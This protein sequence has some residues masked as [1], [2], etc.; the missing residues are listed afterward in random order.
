MITPYATNNSRENTVAT[1]PPV[2]LSP[3]SFVMSTDGQSSDYGAED[4]GEHGT[5]FFVILFCF[6]WSWS[7][8]LAKN[9]MY[10]VRFTTDTPCFKAR[11]SQGAEMRA[12]RG[13]SEKWTNFVNSLRRPIMMVLHIITDHAAANPKIYVTTTILLSLLLVGAGLFTNFRVESDE[14]I[15]YTPFGSRPLQHQAWIDDESGFP[16]TP[17][18][19][20]LLVHQNG[21]NVLHKEGARRAMIALNTCF[22]TP[23]YDEFC[24]QSE[25]GTCELVSFA[26]FWNNSLATFDAQIQTDRDAISIMSSTTFPDGSPV[27]WQN[28]YGRAVRDD[29]GMLVEAFAY[30]MH[31]L[32]PDVDDAEAFEQRALDTLQALRDEWMNEEGNE[33]QLDLFVERSFSDEFS[34]A[35]VADIPLVPMVFFI[36]SAFT[37]FVFL[38]RDWVY[39][40]SLLGFGA[41]VSVLLS[42]MT[43]YGFLFIIGVPFTSMTQILPFV[44]FGIG[45]DDAFIISNAYARQDKR[46]SPQERIH[47]TMDEVGLSVLL[48]TMTSVVAFGLG[49]MSTI[50]TVYWLCLYAFPTIFIDFLYQITFFVALIIIDERRVQDKRRDC[51]VCFAV[52]SRVGRDETQEEVRESF[53]DRLMAAFAIRVL[54]RWWVKIIVILAFT[55]LLVGCG[56]SA[57]RLT[58]EFKFTDVL[59]D[60]SYVATFWEAYRD[61]AAQSGV[62]MQV[63]FRDVD[64]SDAAIQDQME[65]YVNDLINDVPQVQDQEVF[66]WLRDFKSFVNRTSSVR[67]LPFNLQVTRFLEED[68]YESLYG[69]HIVR[70]EQGNILSSRTIVQMQDIDQDDVTQTIDAL[71]AQRAVSEKQPINQGRDDWAFF[72]FDT[73]YFIWEFYTAAPRELTLTVITGVS[74][75]TAIALFCIP[76]WT[77]AL[78]V[79][80]MIVIL[81]VDLLGVLQLAGIHVNVVSYVALGEFRF[82][83]VCETVVAI[84]VGVVLTRAIQSCRLG[85]WLTF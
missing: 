68:V 3:P 60:D 2:T 35:I 10:P 81:Y 47:L 8:C 77:A 17:R 51:L 79:G 75:V 27:D 73:D 29:D 31:I 39:S 67:N 22:K 55:G 59:P 70:D 1:T 11:Y 76:H 85:Y 32:V 24:A 63:Y 69:D 36:M 74:A 28:M 34:R 30:F 57:S 26:K 16:S 53:F 56:F 12:T 19:M 14:D 21:E 20:L 4:S 25:A 45:L 54:G 43:G 66:F 49:C 80:P 44:M 5:F 65:A 71:A 64:Q 52:G 84:P 62:R 15:L 46:K 38:R 58:Q 18:D 7:L 23:G 9:D 82:V 42:I 83:C 78:F 6:L 41:V 37:C 61:L 40:R 48:T 13:F 72:T 50:P 33:V